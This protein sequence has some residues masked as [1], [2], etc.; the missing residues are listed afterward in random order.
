MTR[1]D[2]KLT[3]SAPFWTWVATVEAAHRVRLPREVAG[4]VS[5]LNAG[6]QPPE[7]VGVPGRVGGVQVQPLATHEEEVRRFTEAL[8]D[9]PASSSDAAQDWMDVARLLATVW[10]INISS[11]SGRFSLTLPEPARRMELLPRAG[12][13]VV[14]FVFGDVLE[15]WDASRWHERV[16]GTA[17]RKE[18]AI[19]AAIE[20][21][22][23]R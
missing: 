13:T 7:C 2:H 11:E 5:W 6:A 8:G 16:R 3:T 14:V 18:A 12:G 4:A 19:A 1:G 15:V 21:L 10:T 9:T 22:Q 23:R 17:A 20:D